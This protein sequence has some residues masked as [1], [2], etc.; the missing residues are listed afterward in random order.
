MNLK[1][2]QFN[3]V[4]KRNDDNI[5]FNTFTKACVALDDETFSLLQGSD[6]SY[7]ER[8]DSTLDYLKE[9]GFLVSAD[10]DE[11]AFL[12]Y[13]NYKVRFAE[14]Y[15]SLTIAPTLACN[16]DCPYCFENKRGGTIDKETQSLIL[17][18]LKEKLSHGVK[19]MDLTWY[20]GEP[21]IC[22]DI[23]KEMCREIVTITSQLDV[24]CK[25]GMI[26][27]GYL[28]NNEVADLLE[29]HL[30]PDNA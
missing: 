23:I 5:V 18:F 4:Y 17:E 20:G 11:V 22:F 21:L 28:I 24:Q 7:T 3:F 15:L 8:E 12:K 29:E 27:N 16:F 13:Y 2:S 25:M 19:K 9:N 30:C 1:P 26:T 14:D 6:I 10:F